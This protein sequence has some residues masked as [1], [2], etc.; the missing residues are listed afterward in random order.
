MRQRKP[1][2]PL[3]SANA[4][5]LFTNRLYHALGK[6]LNE[7]FYLNIAGQLHHAKQERTM[8]WFETLKKNMQNF[9]NITKV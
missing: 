4:N 2:W 5:H 3:W 6:Q 9:Q 7:R 8:P 1:L